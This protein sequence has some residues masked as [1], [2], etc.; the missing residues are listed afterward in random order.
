MTLD[1]FISLIPNITGALVF[2]SFLDGI[3][4]LEHLV[5]YYHY[6]QEG[7][8]EAKKYSSQTGIIN[9]LGDTYFGEMYTESVSLER[10]KQM[11]YSNMDII[12]HLK[13]YSP[14]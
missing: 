5:P 1:R 6:F 9:I 14:F 8:V 2:F 7:H 12:I 13:K 4:R 3:H 11:P 10:D